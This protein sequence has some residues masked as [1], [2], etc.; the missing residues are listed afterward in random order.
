VSEPGYAARK[1]KTQALVASMKSIKHRCLI[2]LIL[3]FNGNG[4]A[5]EELERI[6]V[7]P[8][9]TL[10]DGR[11]VQLF[12]LVNE[13]GMTVEIMD[14]GG[15]IV[16]LTAADF[17][18]N[19]VD[20]TT[21]FDSP[22]PY[23]DGAGFMGAI[24]GRYANRIAD[25]RFSID[26]E[27]YSLAQNNGDNAIHGGLVGFDK[28]IWDTE[29]FTNTN[30]AQLVLK[31]FSEDGEEGFPGRMEVTVAY[32]LTDQNQLIVDYYAATDKATVINLTNHA[33]FNLDGHDAGSIS[34]HEIAIYADRYTPV[35]NESIPTGEIVEVANTPLDFR[36]AKPIGRDIDSAHQQIQFGS[37]F[38]H[39]FV[40]NHDEPGLVSLAASVYSPKT[41]RIMNVYTDQPGVQF[42]TG[43]FLN[44]QLV[45]KDG[46]VYVRRGAFCLET[47]HYP[48]SPNKPGF[49]S[50]ILR[51]GEQY[52]TRTIF[53]FGASPVSD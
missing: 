45:G 53:E 18:G 23:A 43:N 40:I 3:I 33:Y 6:S 19:F 27:D 9:G 46:A 12:T 50:T 30:E 2:V 22:Q 24:V 51:P 42:Y 29:Y 34:D 35:D 16:S 4:L 28:K 11:S 47:Q 32:R 14:L 8:F 38:D 39:N 52:E 48:D 15:I 13:E 1:L 7:R 21:G 44:G 26:G 41:G 37:G 25:G 10:E 17:D 36:R 20:V 5:Q 49:P 31:T